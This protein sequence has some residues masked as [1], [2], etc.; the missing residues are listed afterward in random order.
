MKSNKSENAVG[1]FGS[2]V[3]EI[4]ETIGLTQ[5]EMAEKLV[6]HSSYLSEIETGLRKP[7]QKFLVKLASTFNVNLNWLII[8]K[9]KRFMEEP[10]SPEAVE[11]QHFG[12]QKND[13]KELMAYCRESTLVRLT[14]IA[15]FKKFLLKYEDLIHKDM[16]KNK[17]KT[18]EEQHEA[19]E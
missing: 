12:E 11:W 10:G 14:V 5:T 3:R 15:Y 18:E 2:R 16:D 4:R 1:T 6:M 8:G 19:N 7:G 9:G 17:P 13:I